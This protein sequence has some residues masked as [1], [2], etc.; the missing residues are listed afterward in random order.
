MM[1]LACDKFDKLPGNMRALGLTMER[2]RLVADIGAYSLVQTVEGA[3]ALPPPER[4]ID[5][6]MAFGMLSHATPSLRVVEGIWRTM[7]AEAGEGS[8]RLV[9]LNLAIEAARQELKAAGA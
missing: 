5:W 1:V 4:V 6:R 8:P 3:R 2:L 7:A 9:E